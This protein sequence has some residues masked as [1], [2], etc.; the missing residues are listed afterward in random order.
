MAG[1]QFHDARA[2][3]FQRPSAGRCPGPADK[4]A[5]L[6]VGKF[7][8]VFGLLVAAAGLLVWWGVPLGRLPGDIV[9]KRESFSFYV[10][11]T[12]AIVVSVALTLLMALFRR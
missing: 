9:V 1:P 4:D 2:N 10:P 6:A 5:A 7:L 11:I 8:V 12:T 3:H